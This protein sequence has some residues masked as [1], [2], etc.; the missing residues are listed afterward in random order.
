LF[1]ASAEPSRAS[2]HILLPTPCL[3]AAAAVRVGDHSSIFGAFVGTGNFFTLNRAMVFYHL[4]ADAF[5]TAILPTFT[6]SF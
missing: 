1:N 3:Q 4:V 6:F 2:P 5:V